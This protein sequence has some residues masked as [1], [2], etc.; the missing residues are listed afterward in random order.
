MGA[1]AG[2]M[3]AFQDLLPELQATVD[4]MRHALPEQ[5]LSDR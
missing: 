3:G 1:A 2:V 5:A 4:R